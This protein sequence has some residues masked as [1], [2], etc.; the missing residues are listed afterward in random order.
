MKKLLISLG[1]LTLLAACTR[2]QYLT[3]ESDLPLNDRNEF[4]FENESFRLS[5]YFVN[6]NELRVEVKNKTKNFLIIDWSKSSIVHQDQYLPFV[7]GSISLTGVARQDIIGDYQTTSTGYVDLGRQ[8]E[9]LPSK[10]TTSRT[11]NF[12]GSDLRNLPFNQ[13]FERIHLGTTTGKRYQFSSTDSTEFFES[14]IFINSDQEEGNF[15]NHHFWVS[16]LV[17]CVDGSPNKLPNQ[18]VFSK[19]T[20]ASNVMI[21]AVVLPLAIL[22]ASVEEDE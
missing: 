14:Y 5:Y 20:G 18:V 19:L 21:G 10:G 4:L 9:H 7:D 2:R 13:P 15:L 11:M 8:T 1:L 3:F 16:S 17:E 22:A 12:L 6:D